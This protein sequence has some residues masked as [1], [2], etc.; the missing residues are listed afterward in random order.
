MCLQELEIQ[1]FEISGFKIKETLE[2]F[3]FI[4][5]TLR[6]HKKMAETILIF[7]NLFNNLSNFITTNYLNLSNFIFGLWRFFFN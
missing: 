6:T 2:M 5:R 7:L 3:V 4:I 1:L